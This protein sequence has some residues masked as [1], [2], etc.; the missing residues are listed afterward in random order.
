M[1][2][3]LVHVMKVTYSGNFY[4]VQE[5]HAHSTFQH[6]GFQHVCQMLGALSGTFWEGAK[7][8]LW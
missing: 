8:E 6:R 5:V 7:R 2:I 3:L 4:T 1:Y